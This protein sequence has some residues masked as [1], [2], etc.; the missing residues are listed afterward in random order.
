M[1]EQ[2]TQAFSEIAGLAKRLGIASIKDVDGCWEYQ[3]DSA[4]WM[5]VNGHSVPVKCSKAHSVPAYHAYLEYNGWP[6]GIISPFGGVIADG[7]GANEDSFIAALRR[8][9]TLDETYGREWRET[10]R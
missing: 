7:T 6:A 5:A 3:I 9:S 10:P 2:L 1:G 4:W 8:V